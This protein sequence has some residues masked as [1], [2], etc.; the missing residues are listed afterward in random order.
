MNHSPTIKEQSA[1][2]SL[3][4]PQHWLS[5]SAEE[6]AFAVAYVEAGYSLQ[7]ASVAS[8]LGLSKCQKML[9]SPLVRKAIHEVQ[10]ALGEIDFL[11]EKWVREQLLKIYPKLV[12]EESIPMMDNMGCQIE[13]RKFHPEAALRVL[14]YVAPKSLPGKGGSGAAVSVTINMGAMGINT[15]DVKE[16]VD[17]E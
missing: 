15:V 2:T 8:G 17:G 16:T 1:N 4:L 14:E 3:E 6:K 13:G 9:G 12:G 5:L 7:G 10:S 11:N